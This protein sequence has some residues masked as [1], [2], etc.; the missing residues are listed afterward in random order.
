MLKLSETVKQRLEDELKE[1]FKSIDSSVCGAF[2]EV[3]FIEDYNTDKYTTCEMTKSDLYKILLDYLRNDFIQKGLMDGHYEYEVGE[4]LDDL[5]INQI[6]KCSKDDNW[7]NKFDNDSVLPAQLRNSYYCDGDGAQ[8]NKIY[9]WILRVIELQER[10]IKL[11]DD[12]DK[13]YISD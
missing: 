11:C 12:I 9:D 13:D 4:C 2:Y 1:I 5:R 7:V 3:D 8:V 6:I 10:R